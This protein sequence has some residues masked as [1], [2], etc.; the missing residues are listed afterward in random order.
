MLKKK[1]IQPSSDL[2]K[3]PTIM[4]KHLTCYRGESTMDMSGNIVM[5][6]LFFVDGSEQQGKY[7][8]MYTTGFTNV[9]LGRWWRDMTGVPDR[10]GGTV[11]RPHLVQARQ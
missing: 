1:N 3:H 4:P 2:N 11:R 8:K 10:V 7:L 6:T 9:V 5:N